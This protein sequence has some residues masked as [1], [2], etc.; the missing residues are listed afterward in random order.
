MRKDPHGNQLLPR[1][2]YKH[3]AYWHVY[4]NKWRRIGKTYNAALRE[5]SALNTSGG[6]M[7]ALINQTYDVYQQREKD[8]TLTT[9]SLISYQVVRETLC[10]AFQHLDPHEVTPGMVRQ[11][12]QH[13]YGLKPGAGNRAIV[14]LRAAFDLAIDM[15]LC[16]SNPAQ[17]VKQVHSKPRQRL[18]TD[19]EF[20]RVKAVATGQVPLVMDALYYTG[21]RIR[22]VLAIKQ[23]SIVDGVIY[24]V[25]QK[26]GTKMPIQIGPEL[27]N[28][29]QAAR[30]GP[31]TGLYLF[32]T[33]GKA[34]S[35][36]TFYSAF[37]TACKRAGVD[38]FT[39]H[40]IRRKAINDYKAKGGDP[41]LLAGHTDAKMTERYLIDN[42]VKFIASLDSL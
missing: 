29:I 25:Q 28:V 24:M 19:A 3:G 33:H 39:P 8:G 15:D 32:S 30:S 6:G 41:Q 10:T 26:T 37:K 17:Q 11:F 9:G 5:Y 23:S 31:V 38:N 36:Y 13:Y 20:N 16:H 42:S 22:D 27:A 14:V 7:I 34:L 35:Y 4:R 2:H 18:P 40:D 12:R 1:M 21:Q